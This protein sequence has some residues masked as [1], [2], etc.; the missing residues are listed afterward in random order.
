M[1]QYRAMRRASGLA[2]VSRRG[3]CGGVDSLG[4]L[5]CARHGAPLTYHGD[6]ISGPASTGLVHYAMC[7]MSSGHVGAIRSQTVSKSQRLNV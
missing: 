5:Y 2:T 6:V 3:S 4:E 7:T 1:I